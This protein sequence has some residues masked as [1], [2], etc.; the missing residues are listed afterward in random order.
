MA[1]IVTDLSIVSFLFNS[2][3]QEHSCKSTPLPASTTQQH[4]PL[5]SLD[6]NTASAVSSK[7]P[8][9]NVFPNHYLR[10]PLNQPTTLVKPVWGRPSIATASARPQQHLLVILFSLHLQP[11]QVCLAAQYQSGTTWKELPLILTHE[12]KELPPIKSSLLAS[13]QQALP[14]L[15]QR[16]TLRHL[17]IVT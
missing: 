5:S 10:C 4:L 7:T 17:S 6:Q 1:P 9:A 3:E 11:T 15:P 16:N 12:S 8:A 14:P 13:M 2:F